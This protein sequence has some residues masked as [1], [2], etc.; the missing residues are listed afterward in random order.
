MLVTPPVEVEV[1]PPLVEVDPPLLEVE[2]PPLDVLVE[3]PVVVEVTTTLPPDE[4]PPPKKP[5]KN[6]PPKPPKPPEPP[7][8]V[9][10]PPLDPLTGGSAG[11]GW[12]SGTGIIAICGVQSGPPSSQGASITRRMRLTT[13]GFSATRLAGFAFTYLGAAL[14]T[15]TDLYVV[16]LA[17]CGSATCTAPPP[18]SAPPAAAAD[19]FARAIFTDMV[20]NPVRFRHGLSRGYDSPFSPT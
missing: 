4:L 5:P 11:R 2:L 1:E 17:A 19:S 10:P 12:G 15:L 18:S 9:T 20:S 16:T 13:R 7:T 14:A 8:T 6:P 3:P